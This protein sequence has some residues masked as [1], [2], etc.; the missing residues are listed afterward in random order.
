MQLTQCKNV[1]FRVCLLG[2]LLDSISLV[3]WISHDLKGGKKYHTHR[4]IYICDI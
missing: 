4:Y 1:F 3:D 2:S